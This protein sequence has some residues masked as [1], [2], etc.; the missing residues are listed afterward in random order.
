MWAAEQLLVLNIWIWSLKPVTWH[1]VS[2]LPWNILTVGLSVGSAVSLNTEVEIGRWVECY[3]KLRMFEITLLSSV[4]AG[5]DVTRLTLEPHGRQKKLFCIL[6][7][8]RLNHTFTAVS[9]IWV[10]WRSNEIYTN[11]NAT[12]NPCLLSSAIFQHHMIWTQRPVYQLWLWAVAQTW[13]MCW[14]FRRNMNT[15]V[16]LLTCHHIASGHHVRSFV[17][18]RTHVVFTDWDR[19]RSAGSTGSSSGSLYWTWIS[20]LSL[21]VIHVNTAQVSWLT[22]ETLR[23]SDEHPPNGWATLHVTW[24]SCRTEPHTKD[25][26][27][28]TERIRRR[29]TSE[30]FGINSELV[31]CRPARRCILIAVSAL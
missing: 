22:A 25:N 26:P 23:V 31:C 27:C 19:H 18:H 4:S 13:G 14:S 1:H 30:M 12:M 21:L 7:L 17:T 11:M 16:Q 20:V 6:C 5:S 8:K 29:W 28:E 9:S 3:F 15:P 24:W 10:T 2:F